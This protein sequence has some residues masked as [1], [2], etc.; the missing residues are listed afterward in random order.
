MPE[1]TAL[2][3]VHGLFVLAM[4][5]LG[6]LI[7]S[8]LNVVIHRLPRM[9]ERQWQADC[10]SLS[11]TS[12]S[13]STALAKFNLVVPR[14]R[15][16]HCAAMITAI[17]NI[18]LVSYWCLRGRC[19][20]CKARISIRYP[21]V[22]LATAILTAVIAAHFGFEWTALWA[23]LLTWSLIALAA[24]D[25]DTQFLPDAIT[26]PMLWLGLLL[27]GQGVFVDLH[28]AVIGAALGYLSLWSIYWL[29]KLLTNKEGMGYGDFKLLGMLGA[30]LGWK[31]LPIIILSA[32]LVGAVVGLSLIA[33]AGRD[34]AQPIPFGPYLA[35][36]GWI[37]LL[38]GD[39]LADLFMG[40]GG[41]L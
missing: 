27:N 37:T 41:N 4:G 31:M 36:A 24:I 12:L 30:W 28:S 19:R 34:R 15:C 25:F 14:S 9:M 16:P 11:S 5:G 21:L 32:S 26:L 3:S 2:Y 40:Y 39:Q 22:E 18:P 6:L 38:W 7:G 8:F 23:A 10:A 17:D 1:G 20:H 29:F 13:E 33:F 35:A